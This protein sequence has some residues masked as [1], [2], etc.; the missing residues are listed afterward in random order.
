MTLPDM[1]L[2]N[3]V[4]DVFNTIYDW[5][6]DPKRQGNPITSFVQI[7]RLFFEKHDTVFTVRVEPEFAIVLDLVK[8]YRH[9]EEH[10]PHMFVFPVVME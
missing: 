9:G 6:H 4:D 7:P 2:Q 10:D 5:A 3:L 8:K 1:T